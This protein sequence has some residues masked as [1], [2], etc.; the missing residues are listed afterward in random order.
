MAFL[1]LPNIKARTISAY[2]FRLSIVTEAN[3][4]KPKSS[5]KNQCKGA[6]T[7]Q[8]NIEKEKNH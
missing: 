7:E 5:G 8:K 3:S 4:E 6:K 1:S 2:I